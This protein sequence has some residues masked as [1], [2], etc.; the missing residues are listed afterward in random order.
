MFGDRPFLGESIWTP[1]PQPQPAP[2]PPANPSP[3]YGGEYVASPTQK[4]FKND[5]GSLT[6]YKSGSHGQPQNFYDC[7]RPVQP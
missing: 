2:P 4:G 3:N 5:D 7:G 6:G 1:P